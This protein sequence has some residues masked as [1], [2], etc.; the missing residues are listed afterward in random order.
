MYLSI[1]A[2]KA[3]LNITSAA[4]DAL[5]TDLLDSA[6]KAI[7]SYCRRRFEATT[8]TRYYRADSVYGDVLHLDDDL[9]S[10][11]TLTNGEG[12]V[13]TSAN[14]FL[15]PRNETPKGRIRLK[16]GYTWTFNTDGEISIAGSWGWSSTPPADVVQ[17]VKRL[18]AF[19]YKQRDAQ[20]FETV[21]LPEIG[22]LRIPP[23]IPPDVKLLL[24]PFVRVTDVVDFG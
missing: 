20:I 14:Y 22:E 3:Y 8:T 1:E 12:T 5:L 19:E 24:A 23:V 21:A 13:I 15:E 2:L 4:D 10:V 9:L 16:S 18:C 7:E 17:A 11:T 6:Q